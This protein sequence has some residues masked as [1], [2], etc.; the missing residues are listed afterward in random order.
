[1]LLAVACSGQ[2]TPAPSSSGVDPTPRATAPAASSRPVTAPPSPRPTPPPYVDLGCAELIA[3]RPGPYPEPT[4]AP[5]P[6]PAIAN[7]DADARA[8]IA[9]AV[10][11]LVA[12]R[13]YAFTVDV[14]ARDINRLEPSSLDFGL[15]G[16]VD[17]TNGFAVDA[18]LGTRM[19]ET[20]GTGA[21]VSVTDRIVAGQGYVWVTDRISGV[22]EPAAS[23]AIVAAYALLTPEGF[24]GRVVVPFAAGYRRVGTERHGGVMTEHYRRSAGGAK[25]YAAALQF[26]G[27]VKADLWIAT[28][29]GYLVAARIA[30]SGSHR[31]PSTGIEIDDGFLLAF[32][33]T[34]PNDPANAVELPAIPVPDP[35]RPSQPPVDLQ[36]EYQVLPSDGTEPT[37]ADLDQIG[38]TLRTRLDVSVRP[39]KVDTPGSDRIVVTICG[40]S[41][42]D[43]DRRLV[44]APGALNVVPLPADEYGSVGAP[45]RTAL[46]AA[47]DPIDPALPP[48]ALAGGAGL[49]TAHVDPTT[50]RRGLAFRLGNQQTDAFLAHASAHPGEYVAV[51]LDGIVLATVSIEGQ[52]AKGNFV[53]TGDYTE[54][55]SRLL[56]R[57][58][59]RSPI[60]FPLRL[61]DEIEVQSR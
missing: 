39:V 60:P 47:G 11:A 25:A 13:S 48:V 45:G 59:Y 33:V 53:F 16:T 46:P 42:P 22:L 6:Q 21:S 2:P 40:T 8:A 35:V 52:T 36:L 50:G 23:E 34:R 58:L 27:D 51:I 29:G 17:H 4:L 14:V 28:D 43:G 56:A 49:T 12:L 3:S 44:A 19:R 61:T 1:M 54:A 7:P 5:P 9:R 30:G 10:D 15:R 57:L 20:N 32:D 18:L 38:V 55:E 41:D 24:A 31:D 26:D 37:A